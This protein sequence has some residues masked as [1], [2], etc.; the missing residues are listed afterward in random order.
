MERAWNSKQKKHSTGKY[1]VKC[2][3]PKQKENK[4]ILCM[5]FSLP[6]SRFIITPT[7]FR[8][9]RSP[10]TILFVLCCRWSI[11]VPALLDNQPRSV[12]ST[13]SRIGNGN[14]TFA[15]TLRINA[16]SMSYAEYWWILYLSIR[17]CLWVCRTASRGWCIS[18]TLATPKTWGGSHVFDYTAS[19]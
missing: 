6:S 5:V 10:L 13:D 17:P 14:D 9:L 15:N 3:I 1:S 8:P 19:A 4:N 2:K 16:K 11:D 12:F 7:N 18:A